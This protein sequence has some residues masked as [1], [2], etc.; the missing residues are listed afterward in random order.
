MAQ[1]YDIERILL[2][3]GQDL[4]HYDTYYETPQTT[5]GTTLDADTRRRKL[6]P[7]VRQAMVEEIDRLRLIAPVDVVIVSGNHDVDTSFTLGDSIECWYHNDPAV[8]VDNGPTMRKYYRY[9]DNLLGFTHG[10]EEPFNRLPVLMATECPLDWSVTTYREWQVGHKHRTRNSVPVPLQDHEGVLVREL[11]SLCPPDS[12][13]YRKGFLHQRGAKAFLW[14]P[15]GG[16]AVEFT[17][18]VPRGG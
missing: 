6:Y 10:S 7:A 3:L 16:V 1:S 18:N 12:W 8:E 9:G 2:P 11:P 15:E 13:H 5:K 17:L 14:H 4:F